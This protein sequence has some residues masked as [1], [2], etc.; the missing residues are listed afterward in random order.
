MESP[1]SYYVI[2]PLCN[3]V[4]IEKYMKKKGM[5]VLKEEEAIFFLKQIALGF[6]E[7]HRNN[8]VHRD[9]KPANCF[10]HDSN[11]IVA[12]LGFARSAARLMTTGCGSPA[13]MAPEILEMKSGYNTLVDMWSIGASFYQI[14]F[15]QLPFNGRDD[16][17]II[18][19]IKRNSGQNLKIPL[20][21]NNI[22]RDCQELLKSMLTM[23]PS[24]RLSWNAFF[25]HKLFNISD[26][27]YKRDNYNPLGSTIDFARKMNNRFEVA[28]RADAPESQYTLIEDIFTNIN[29]ATFALQP[30]ATIVEE[31]EPDSTYVKYVEEEEPVSDECNNRYHH[32]LR[33]IDCMRTTAARIMQLS[34]DLYN[35][36]MNQTNI[37]M[38]D[39]NICLN[40]C[41]IVL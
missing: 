28:R 22:S 33:K 38:N 2:L 41:C 37:N 40:M 23:E 3:N 19:D 7:L 11:C 10:M 25:N 35:P 32:E 24:R 21:I 13:Y 15:G 4:D 6:Q 18:M 9:F 1:S 30:Q 8:I 17:G 12:D 31:K 36:Y 16:R 34:E 5:S 29:I 14:L 26:S 20:R 39:V 27:T